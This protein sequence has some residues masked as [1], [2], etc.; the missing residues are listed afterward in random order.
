MYV[1]LGIGAHLEYWGISPDKFVEFDW[2][3]G[4]KRPD[5]IEVVATPARHFSGRGFK[6][7]KTLWASFVLKIH[8][9][10]IY[11]GGDS[12]YEQHFK[13]IG[14]KYGPFDIAMLECGQYGKD[15]PYIHMFPEQVAIAAKDLNAK[16][17]FPVHWGK[18]VL[19]THD[20]DDPVKRVVKAA[21]E[22]NINVTTPM[23]GEPIVLDTIYPKQTW[24]ELK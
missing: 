2:W 6:R 11:I 3:E 7:A 4:E 20:W 24:W 14:E 13:Q 1:P 17:L 10:S 23:I 21:L 9:Y 12:G 18:F 16:V 8:G 15:W 19:S 22:N 5:G